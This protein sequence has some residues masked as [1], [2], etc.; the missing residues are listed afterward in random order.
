M[1]LYIQ[2]KGNNLSR[3]KLS[4]GNSLID[5]NNKTAGTTKNK[6]NYHSKSSKGKLEKTERK[7]MMSRNERGRR[8][9]IL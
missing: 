2:I 3:K 5:Q 6:N 7:R 4:K 1:V 8:F 9:Y